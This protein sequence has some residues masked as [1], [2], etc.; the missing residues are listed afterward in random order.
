MNTFSFK[1]VWSLF[2]VLAFFGMFF[3]LVFTTYFANLIAPIR[4]GLGIVFLIYAV[5][6]VWQVLNLLKNQKRNR[7]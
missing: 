5:F 2:M 7:N 6:R 3:I 1:I 4:I